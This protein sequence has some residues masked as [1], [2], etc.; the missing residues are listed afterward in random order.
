MICVPAFVIV[1][2]HKKGRTIG[3]RYERY[4]QRHAQN[5]EHNRFTAP[6][7]CTHRSWIRRRGCNLT[8]H[9]HYLITYK[10]G[11]YQSFEWREEGNAP[12]GESSPGNLRPKMSSKCKIGFPIRKVRE[13]EGLI[14]AA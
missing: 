9:I 6:P 3:E 5:A 14:P 8:L 12:I 7:T 11:C 2:R 10:P 1:D 13:V 4:Q